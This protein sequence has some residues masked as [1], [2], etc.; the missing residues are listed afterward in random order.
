[1][2][3][4]CNGNGLINQLIN[5]LGNGDLS[6]LYDPNKEFAE[7]DPNNNTL[8]MPNL[9]N[10]LDL[11]PSS[12]D[13]IQNAFDLFHELFHVYQYYVIGSSN[14]NAMRPEIEIEAKL[15][16]YY[17]LVYITNYDYPRVNKIYSSVVD[18]KVAGMAAFLNYNMSP[19]FSAYQD[20][21][22]VAFSEAASMYAYDHGN[23]SYT[24][25]NG[26]YMPN[27]SAIS[28]DC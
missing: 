14:W 7:Y 27:V 9:H 28:S 23:Y 20:L 3:D 5:K 25:S 18:Q 12:I 24:P 15:A 6:I 26:A 11:S 17:Y 1:M 19:I 4:Q 2:E 21:I 10:G 13:L 22:D 16:S 8:T